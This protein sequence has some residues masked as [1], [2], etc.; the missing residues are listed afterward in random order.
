MSLFSPVGTERR[1]AM[2]AGL[3]VAIGLAVASV[4]VMVIGQQSRLFERKTTYRAYFTNVQGLSDE[5]PVW[6][7]GLNVGRVTGIVFS[8]DPKDPRLE[9]QFQVSSRYTDRVRQDSVAQLSSMGVLGDKAVDISLGNPT[10]PPVEA[11][12]VLKSSSSGDL[13][14]L[15]NGASQVMENSV[16]ISKSLRAA[17]DTYANPEMASDVTRGMA[18]LRA[19][20]EEVEKGEGVLHALIY[21]KQAGREVRGLL[22]NASNAAARVDGAVGELEGILREVRTGDGT[23]HA[24]VYGQDGAKALTELGAAAGQLAGLIEDA[25][26][27]PNGAVHQLVY[28]DA[29][30]MFAD[31]G[32]AA[33]D[34]KQI[35]ATVA[36]GDGTVGGL[37]SDPTV[38]EDLR[39]VLGNVKRNR[40]LRALVRFSLSN[41]QDLDQVGKVEGVEPPPEAPAAHP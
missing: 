33:A 26:K 17:V 20:L 39:E 34:L 5:S 28:G 12:G 3:F 10:A 35:T 27:S 29:S 24:L 7:G 32:S 4:V 40:I 23:A 9:V 11:G 6:L 21:D 8:P 2:R 1:L 19:L 18:A 30:G 38:Y 13:S 16:A 41:R 36:K 22:A 31:L 25:K 37:I 14:A 15:L